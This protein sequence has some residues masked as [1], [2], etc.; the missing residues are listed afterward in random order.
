MNKILKII[1]IVGVACLFVCNL[2]FSQNSSFND[3]EI[4]KPTEE[5]RKEKPMPCDIGPINKSLV[6]KTWLFYSC[7][8]SKSAVVLSSATKTASVGAYY[9]FISP[10]IKTSKTEH[11]QYD[12]IGGGLA[13]KD[14]DSSEYKELMLL[15][16]I[17]VQGLIT[18]SKAA[19]AQIAKY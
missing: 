3:K 13:V 1:K 8:D 16:R 14:I 12:V 9:Y 17:D 19:F 7:K 10:H 5:K 4:L 18:Q 2:C 15:S 6:G 11:E